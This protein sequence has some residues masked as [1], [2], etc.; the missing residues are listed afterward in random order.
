MTRRGRDRGP[1]LRSTAV[2]ACVALVVTLLPSVAAS[3]EGPVTITFDGP[4]A[5]VGQ[6]AA[7]VY[8]E[9]RFNPDP[10]V[11]NLS[12]SCTPRVVADASPP[13]AP[14]AVV[15]W[16]PGGEF[17]L[18]GGLFGQLTSGSTGSVSLRFGGYGT[19]QATTSFVLEAFDSGNELL[20]SATATGAVGSLTVTAPQP[21][22]TAFRIRPA[23]QAAIGF[24]FW[25]DDI[26]WTPVTVP[27]P[28]D[29]TLTQPAGTGG[30]VSVLEGGT[31]KPEQLTVAP[32]NGSAGQV[33]WSVT[34]LPAGVAGTV[35]PN[36]GGGLLT[37]TAAEGTDGTSGTVTVTA[38]PVD[39]ATGTVPHSVTYVVTVS[40]SLV[41]QAPATLDVPVC[42]LVPLGVVAF[43]P[44][45]P[46]VLTL[47]VQP[48]VPGLSV[49]LRTQWN[50]I[51]NSDQPPLVSETTSTSSPFV[52]GVNVNSASHALL[53]TVDS[54]K[55]PAD[56]ATTTVRLTLSG[57]GRSITR[58][59]AVT[60]HR[61]RLTPTPSV[62]RPERAVATSDEHT[63]PPFARLTVGVAP[64]V[65]LCPGTTV[66]VGSAAWQPVN[67]AVD[68]SS[69][70]L[71]VPRDATSGAV[72]V[73][74][75]WFGTATGG[76]V[77]V[78]TVRNTTGFAFRNY[79]P[80]FDF[81]D[82]VSAF[83]VSAFFHITLFPGIDIPTPVP[84][85]EAG[86]VLGVANAVFDG[87]CYGMSATA[88]ELRD[89]KKLAAYAPAGAPDAWHLT[90]PGG[91]SDSL[92]HRIAALHL[93]QLSTQ[94]GHAYFEARGVTEAMTPDQLSAAIAKARTSGDLPVLALAGGGFHVV[95]VHDV[96]PAGSGAWDVDVYDPNVPYTSAEEAPGSG[97]AA[98]AAAL[99]NS[100]LHVQADGDW[101]LPGSTLSNPGAGGQVRGMALMPAG[102]IPTSVTLPKFSKPGD[103]ENALLLVFGS[104]P[105]T[106]DPARITAIRA[107]AV[108]PMLD[109]GTGPSGD[110]WFVDAGAG[111]VEVDVSGTA[112]G[113]YRQT[114]LA[115]GFGAAVSLPSAPGREATMTLDP[116]AGSVGLEH[117]TV[118]GSVVVEAAGPDGSGGTRTASLTVP[119]AAA[120][121]DEVGVTRTGEV[122][123]EHSGRPVTA[124]LTL[125]GAHGTASSTATATVALGTGT[126]TL[127][128]S[129]WDRLGGSVTVTGPSGRQA[130]S[131][132]AAA[133][134][135]LKVRGVKVRTVARQRVAMARI[136][137]QGV[138]F[139]DSLKAV[140]TAVRGT[141]VLARAT[142]PVTGRGKVRTATWRLPAAAKGT[143]VVVVPL[144]VRTRGL[145]VTTVTGRPAAGR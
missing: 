25:V 137:V 54:A 94:F 4:P 62:V 122:V 92:R 123:V 134:P 15:P 63:T 39:A 30:K 112:G 113:T 82:V 86:I 104:G 33:T 120:G 60:V 145:A 114:V 37:F 29:F 91:P 42:G 11:T 77:T 20:A 80:G 83:G 24:R 126:T 135:T 103:A 85:P 21:T 130:V 13:S 106:S 59:I 9:V 23:N 109:A 144:L 47:A 74:S 143:R 31:S 69:V 71:S 10:N 107:R 2:L 98:H 6:S 75:D 8:P 99:A 49:K 129:R 53:V 22:I 139:G 36:Q 48:P 90:G 81:G 68:G 28:P 142:L 7:T 58:Q 65:R 121:T 128:P 34:G 119:G 40:T 127:R 26:T 46:G 67:L 66:K 101:S 44:T 79:R 12:Y 27:L 17:D 73:R 84:S 116:S 56:T 5:V 51:P 124:T 18:P 3:A 43:P 117:G 57:G 140:W 76:P 136:S 16:C 32:V 61:P 125:T 19:S 64:P 133:S 141:T 41:L 138:A 72:H 89:P 50:Q 35:T 52:T 118:P 97:D 115:D 55:L 70:N 78:R 93:T 95:L 1:I 110:G 38:T 96:R 132:R 105:G 100:V 111:P 14:N 131:L 108:A 45:S 87:A 102:S 88:L